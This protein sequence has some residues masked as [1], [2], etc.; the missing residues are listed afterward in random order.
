MWLLS[1][2]YLCT[3]LQYVAQTTFGQEADIMPAIYDHVLTKVL[4]TGTMLD[5][6][7]S[8]DPAGGV[9]W[10]KEHFGARTILLSSYQLSVC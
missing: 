2:H 3:R 5:F 4:P 9:H 10:Y 7:P 8:T 1:E 6:G